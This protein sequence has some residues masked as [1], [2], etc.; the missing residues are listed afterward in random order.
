M[1]PELRCLG[2]VLITVLVAFV[3]WL[4]TRDEV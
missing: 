3:L 2:L 1:T 4:F